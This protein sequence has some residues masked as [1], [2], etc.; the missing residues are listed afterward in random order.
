MIP[1]LL[2]Q[3]GS[4]PHSPTLLRNTIHHLFIQGHPLGEIMRRDEKTAEGH[5]RHFFSMNMKLIRGSQTIHI[6]SELETRSDKR[7]QLISYRLTKKEGDLRI[8]S[9]GKVKDFKLHIS[10]TRSGNKTEEV[11]DFPKGTMSALSYDLYLWLNRNALQ[12][13]ETHI[14]HEDLGTFAHQSSKIIRSEK[15]LRIEHQALGMQTHETYDAQGEL[16]SAHTLEIDLWALTPGNL[17]PKPDEESLNIMDIST[18]KTK[19]LPRKV[20]AVVYEV[21]VPG[22]LEFQPFQDQNQKLLSKDD[23]LYTIEV[24]RFQPA[25]IILSEFEKVNLTRTTALE[26]HH[27]PIIKKKAAELQKGLKS[28][29]S[30]IRAVSKF[31]YHHIENKT[32]DRG[33]ASALETLSAK[34]G[35]CT[36]HSILASALL[37]SLGYPTR[38]VDGVIA[39]DQQ[40]GYHEWIEVYIDGQGFVPVDPTFN[41]FPAGPNHLK[42]ALGDSSPEGMIQLGMTATQL[43][44]G[45]EVSIKGFTKAK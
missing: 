21:K 4:Q 15:D 9:E 32:L 20:D 26:P 7:H 28:S 18:W 11:I 24:K 10:T 43:L 25:T 42:F 16:L 5:Y 19:K 37:R 40:L 31:V 38:L 17:P 41:E 12:D 1:L 44:S 22:T 23:L 27:H 35:D 3:G 2:G 39:F 13:F 14:F 30:V 29:E 34:K 45:I 33:A 6:S 8:R 36:E